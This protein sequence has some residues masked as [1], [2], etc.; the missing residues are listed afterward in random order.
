MTNKLV[1]Q[2]PVDLTGASAITALIDADSILYLLGWNHRDHDD[3]ERVTAAADL[4]IQDILVTVQGR[5]YAGFFSDKYTYRH[6]IYPAY[7]ANRR[8][9]DPGIEKWKPY[10]KEHCIENWGF[11]LVSKLEADDAVAILQMNMVNSFICSPDK[12]LKQIPGNHYDYKK[13]VQCHVSEDEGKFNWAYQM[14]VGDSGDNIKGIAG[15][16]PKKAMNYINSHMTKDQLIAAVESAYGVDTAGYK[17]HDKLVGM[18]AFGELSVLQKSLHTFN[19]AE[20]VPSNYLRDA[21]YVQDSGD[22]FGDWE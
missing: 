5:Q 11:G 7:K 22:I 21:G 12:D 3:F 8:E 6:D 19:L 17:L 1:D 9:P 18:G 10:I 15:C 2:E 16:G 13:I 14:L 20:A 4:F